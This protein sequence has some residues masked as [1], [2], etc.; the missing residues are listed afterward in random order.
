[1]HNLE[2][3][4]L[5]EESKILSN[6]SGQ[7]EVI[8]S[9]CC[10]AYN[11]EQFIEQTIQGF[12]L[13]VTDFPYEIILRDDAST[14][15][16]AEIIQRYH[17]RYPNIIRTLLF[18]ENQLQQGKR[19]VHDWP[20]VCKGNYI[21][22]CE[23]DDFWTDSFKLQKQVAYMSEHPETSLCFHRVDKVANDGRV[24]KNGERDELKTWNSAESLSLYVPTLSILFRLADLE[25]IVASTKAPHGDAVLFA[26]LATKGHF[27]DLG[28]VG[29]SY[30]IHREG[31]YSGKTVRQR[32]LNSMLTRRAIQAAGFLTPELQTEMREVIRRKK[33]KYAKKLFRKLDWIGAW[34]VMGA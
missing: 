4:N 33:L 25:K 10:A 23:G 7:T 20:T 3:D 19:P 11:H 15:R 31:M 32:Y 13:Q 26:Y 5:L 18:K 21:A 30:R 9:I 27:T 29:A 14:D 1:M 6:W 12:L 8:V 34:Q 2:L 28:F 24:I 22:M 17:N 16:T